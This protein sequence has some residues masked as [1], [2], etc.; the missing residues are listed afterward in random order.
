MS[1]K[2][3][4]VNGSHSYINSPTLSES[5]N[6]NSIDYTEKIDEIYFNRYEMKNIWLQ[7]G[8]GI[9]VMVHASTMNQYSHIK[10]NN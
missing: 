4:D 1:V 6:N 5:K 10:Y 3:G 2:N 7:D 9:G 8:V